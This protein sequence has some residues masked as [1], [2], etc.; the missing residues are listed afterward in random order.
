[1]K[2]VLMPSYIVFPSRDV[3]HVR[4]TLSYSPSISMTA[5]EGCAPQVMWTVRKRDQ[6]PGFKFWTFSSELRH[7][8][9]PDSM[10]HF[11]DVLSSDRWL[12]FLIL[13]SQGIS[14]GGLPSGWFYSGHQCLWGQFLNKFLNKLQV[15]FTLFLPDFSSKSCRLGFIVTFEGSFGTPDLRTSSFMGRRTFSMPS[16]LPSKG[17][18]L[19]P[20]LVSNHFFPAS[21]SSSWQTMK[22]FD[23]CLCSWLKD[24]T[25]LCPVTLK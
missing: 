22:G 7:L 14:L 24:S 9:S 21:K 25:W 6:I 18:C 11:P 17:I 3:K 13:N 8:L 5:T 20:L 4:D 10:V 15:H 23:C 1:M 19:K 16:H 12:F 2:S